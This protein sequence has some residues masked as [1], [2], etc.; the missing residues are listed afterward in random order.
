[1]AKIKLTEAQLNKIVKSAVNRYLKEATEPQDGNLPT[2][3]RYEVNFNLRGSS[4]EIVGGWDYPEY[5]TFYS[6]ASFDNEILYFD[7]DEKTLSSYIFVNL[8]PDEYDKM[9]YFKIRKKEN[10]TYEWIENNYDLYLRNSP[11]IQNSD[12][13]NSRDESIF[14]S[15]KELF[16]TFNSEQI[17]N[18]LEVHN[19]D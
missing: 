2:P 19:D 14:E 5:E 10:V 9:T 15:P 3:V 13:P 8:C 18:C 12:D 17:E 6:Y 4:E 1:M 11:F 16:D 7:T